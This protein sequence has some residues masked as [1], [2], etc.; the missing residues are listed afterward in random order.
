MFVYGTQFYR[1]PNP[2][3][4][5]RAAALEQ[6][7]GP[8]GFN[9][10]K[11]WVMWN[12]CNPEPGV[13]DFEELDEIMDTCDRLGL[14]VVVNTILETAP[15][16]LGEQH[17]D[18]RYV[19]ADLEPLNLRGRSS[20]PNGGWPGLCLDHSAV[21]AAAADFLAAVAR[22]V[23]DRPSFFGYDCWNEPHVE[24][25]W[26][27][28]MWPTPNQ[29]LFCYCDGTVNEFRL[30][31]A[32]KYET[33]EALNQVWVRRFRAW[34]DVLPPQT[35]GTYADWLDWRRFMIESMSEQM[36]FRAGVLRAADPEHFIMSHGAKF[37]PI[38]PLALSVV[39]NVALVRPLDRWGCAVF[40][41]WHRMTP[42]YLAA[43]FDACRSDARGKP[44]WVA[45]LQGGHG[46][47][48]GL[49]RGSHV[50]PADIRLWNWL[51][52]VAGAGG[53]LYWT[54]MAEAT[55]VEATG[56]GL[57]NAARDI[58]PRAQ[59]AARLC[60]RFQQ[61]EALIE[62]YRCAPQVGI[63]YDT[64]NQ[65]L[66]F[67]MDGKED[68]VT[69]SAQGYYRAVWRSD[70]WAQFLQPDEID[71]AWPHIRVLLVPWH[72]VGKPETAAALDAYARRG[73][74]VICDT[75]L[76]LFDENGRQH[77]RVPAYLHEGWGIRESESFWVAGDG[78]P[79]TIWERMG[80]LGVPAGACAA[81]PDPVSSAPDLEITDPVRG[82]L[83]GR[84]YIT[85][86]ELQ[87]PAEAIGFYR[88]QPVAARSVVG[89]GAVYYFGTNLG[90][91]I[92]EGDETA[93][94]VVETLIRRH[95]TPPIS[96]A[97]LRPRLM[98]GEGEA[99][100]VV[101]N[102]QDERVCERLALPA[103]YRQARDIEQDS[104]LDVDGNAIEVDVD[105]FD[106]RV[107]HLRG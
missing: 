96:G 31:L 61:H 22:Q 28:S 69:G 78:R 48:T 20:D 90:A 50:E 15:Y 17:P 37:P 54:Y 107:I 82:V 2:P 49:Q 1:P 41:K 26:F 13:Y 35:H 70:V 43:K 29:M 73:G 81:P 74:I 63:L 46:M 52:V 8:L 72:I 75:A 92:H 59:E 62:Q 93:L 33:V 94:R 100:L 10:I 105:A 104:W 53:I 76:G 32:R 23:K 79:T 71:G 88:G 4:E 24:P 45:E 58:T 102:E 68:P 95:T 18:A 34:E 67:A 66:S 9:T 38:D 89:A 42:G 11:V 101:I 25:A 7:A 80:P 14:R 3:R 56:F 16:W 77:R 85:P 98:A 5:E 99:L 91:A 57:V 47:V 65:I 64:D 60:A 55:G 87:A 27:N 21:R 106:V 40:P 44:W 97:R 6:I 30:W 12:W 51:A 103:D 84:V 19:N 36:T 86:L 39:D 83:R